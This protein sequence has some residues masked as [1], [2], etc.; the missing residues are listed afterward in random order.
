MN[1]TNILIRIKNRIRR[2]FSY[3]WTNKKKPRVFIPAII[4]AIVLIMVLKPGS[5][6]AT[7]DVKKIEPAEFIQ[8]VSLTGK[9]VPAQKV[10]LGFEYSGRLA[11]VNT[12]V[13]A[14]V[15]KGQNLASLSNGDYYANLQK[16]QATYQSEQAKLADIQKGNRP[17]SIAIARADVDVATQNVAQARLAVVE[18][19]KD[20]FAKS[21]DAVKNKSDS[22][23]NNPRSTNPEL[24][25]FVD[26]NPPLRS[27]VEAQRLRVG[28]I[29]VMWQK[30]STN[31]NANGLTEAQ[32]K[33]SSDYS[34]IIQKFLIDL[35]TAVAS[36][37]S[38]QAGSATF[39]GYRTDISSARSIV[40]TSI[41]TF[42]SAVNDLHNKDSALARANQSQALQLS[43]STP[44]E[45][46]A[47]Q[48]NAQSAAAS[49][50]S[51]SAS[52]SKTVIN[53]PFNGI[54]TRV[55]Y[56]TGESVNAAEPVITLM[57]DASFEIETYVSEN[58]VP[59]LK[60]G[61]TAKVTLDA[62]GDATVFEAVVNQVDL[63][64]TIKDG[65][66]TYRTRL[67]FLSRDERIKSGLTT[68]V[69][70]ETDKRSDVIKV[71]QTAIVISKGKKMVKVAP[72]GTTAWTKDVDASAKLVPV[73]TGTIDRDGDLEVTS[74][75]SAGDIVIVKA[76]K[77]AETK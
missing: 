24:T 41:Q 42:N 25:F 56:K 23:F 5:A 66:V 51:A 70:I 65:V 20:T 35:N 59:K 68:N 54:V 75:I 73:T 44:E 7:Y 74:G 52:L 67:Q 3:V 45:I 19:I 57:S 43:G 47:A 2:F 22:V 1:K 46:K 33:E 13:G 58:D 61:Q 40:N 39:Q 15:K 55:Q 26:G 69:T 12:T 76:D 38:S 4:I 30:L 9:V 34:V 31:V 28:E 8:E 17:E 6:A 62:L 16:S 49:V 37:N 72:A 18:G 36:I 27:S 48:A 63:S 11:R 10:D 50:S 60:V 21:D 29:L 64:E 53:A 32:I 71:P 14:V 77:D